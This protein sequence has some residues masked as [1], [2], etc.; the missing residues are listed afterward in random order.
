[1]TRSGACRYNFIG[2]ISMAEA[3]VSVIPEM[4]RKTVDAFVKKAVEL[5]HDLIEKKIAPV[6]LVCATSCRW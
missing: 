1:M 5:D 6:S 3:L 2:G 4:K